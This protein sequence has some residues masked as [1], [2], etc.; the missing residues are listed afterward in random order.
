MSRHDLAGCA[1]EL[2]DDWEILPSPDEQRLIGLEPSRGDDFR[3]NLVLTV[4]DNGGLSFRDWQVG[5][6]QLLPTQLLAYRLLDLER[7]ELSGHAGGRRLAE[8]V[9][10]G[11]TPVTM[12]Q[13]FALIGRTGCTLTATVSTWRYDDQADALAEIASTLVLPSAS[14]G[15]TA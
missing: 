11:V 6:D 8:H 7:I 3:A 12:E 9:V 4:V 5:S 13:W 15:G 14:E 2:P 10:D 1:L